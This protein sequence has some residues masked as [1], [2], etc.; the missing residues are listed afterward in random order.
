[1]RIVAL[2]IA[3][4]KP[5][6]VMVQEVEGR[7]Q[8]SSFRSRS[9][10]AGCGPTLSAEG[11]ADRMCIRMTRLAGTMISAAGSHLFRFPM[12]FHALLLAGFVS[13][14]AFAAPGDPAVLMKQPALVAALEAVKANEPQ[15]IELQVKLTE[16]PAPPFKEQK[17]AA[18][19]KKYFEEL[20]LKNVFIDPEGNVLGTRPEKQP[21]RTSC[22]ARISTPSFQKRP[23]SP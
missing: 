4:W 23:M 13:V 19:M 6:L 1:M 22:S 14:T 17:R 9:W 10:V 16:I 2:V 20:G 18:V 8:E 12:K 21:S 7:Q 3:R 11:N 5:F 15:T